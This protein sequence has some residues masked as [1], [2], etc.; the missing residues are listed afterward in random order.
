M[1]SPILARAIEIATAIG[2]TTGSTLHRI[3]SIYDQ[4]RDGSGADALQVERE[5]AEDGFE[6]ADPDAFSAR[7]DQVFAR[8]RGQ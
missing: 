4:V 1:V 6:F 2:S 5:V 8:G 7:R 3:R